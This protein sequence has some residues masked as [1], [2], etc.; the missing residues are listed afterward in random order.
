MRLRWVFAP[1]VVAAVAAVVPLIIGA[2]PGGPGRG[3]GE[4]APGWVFATYIVAG[5]ALLAF[6]ALLCA[7]IALG[8]RRG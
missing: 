1:L 4:G 6:I 3:G 8:R 5:L 2:E 7:W